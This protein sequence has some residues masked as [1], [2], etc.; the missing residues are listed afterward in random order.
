MRLT[1]EERD[2]LLTTIVMYDAVE[3][4]TIRALPNPKAKQALE[5]IR[6]LRTIHRGLLDRDE[7]ATEGL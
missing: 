5:Q 3:K 4:L 7:S 2:A 6:E 1:P